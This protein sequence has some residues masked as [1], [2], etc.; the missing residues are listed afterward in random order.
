MGVLVGRFW[1]VL[2]FSA[3]V[4]NISRVR[5]RILH[6]MD[7]LSAPATCSCQRCGR[8]TGS[9]SIVTLDA[10]RAFEACSASA[11]LQAWDAV[12]HVIQERIGSRVVLVKRG[13][14]EVTSFSSDFKSG[15]WSI[16]LDVVRQAI[17]AFSWVSLVC[18]AGSVYELKGLPIG[19][20]LSGLCL[21]STTTKVSSF[22]STSIT[23]TIQ[24]PHL[25]TTDQTLISTT[26]DIRNTQYPHHGWKATYGTALSD[27]RICPERLKNAHFLALQRQVPDVWRP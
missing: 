23:I 19:G 18:V 13:K 14:K 20:V 11:V 2:G 6:A 3:E 8:V 17:R 25:A 15:W 26:L 27:T 10:D 12:Q 24:G 9:V 4:F 5:A 16:S 7:G 22:I 1:T 21:N